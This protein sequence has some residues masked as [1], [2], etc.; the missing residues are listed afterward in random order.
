MVVPLTSPGGNCMAI[1]VHYFIV[2]V[3]LQVK[4]RADH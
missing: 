4:P 1:A 2:S 3:M